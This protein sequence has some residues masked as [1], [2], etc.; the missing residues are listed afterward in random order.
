M[1]YFLKLR[2]KWGEVELAAW[3]ASW[4][5]KKDTWNKKRQPRKTKTPVEDVF[6]AAM[7]PSVNRT[8]IL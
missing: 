6:E 5:I 4:K 7:Q 3:K 8:C 2:E 1:A